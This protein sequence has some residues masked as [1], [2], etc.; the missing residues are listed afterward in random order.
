MQWCRR[1]LTWARCHR[2]SSH[3]VANEPKS[4]VTLL[5]A[6]IQGGQ[7]SE[8]AVTQHSNG[9]QFTR[10]RTLAVQAARPRPVT[11]SASLTTPRRRLQSSAQSAPSTHAGGGRAA[12]GLV[13][14]AGHAHGNTP[15]PHCLP[16]ARPPLHCK[17]LDD[18]ASG[19]PA[20]SACT[21][22]AH[23][24][25]PRRRRPPRASHL[26]RRVVGCALGAAG[27]PFQL[28]TDAGVLCIGHAGLGSG[29]A[30]GQPGSRKGG[31][32]SSDQE[33]PVRGAGCGA[34]RRRCFSWPALEC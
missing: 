21:S 34:Q 17:E 6:R 14:Q 19:T 32:G 7:S 24:Q 13:R 3:F 9:M 18:R 10:R 11:G 16:K 23:A 20:L 12:A 25:R 22:F 29:A 28:P 8:A 15:L 27:H 26:A 2:I 4:V 33:Q 30:C 1:L 31:R 5:Q